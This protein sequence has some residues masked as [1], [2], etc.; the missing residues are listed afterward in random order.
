MG[1][2]IDTYRKDRQ[3]W[4]TGCDIHPD[5]PYRAIADAANNI[6]EALRTAVRIVRTQA[7]GE[8]AEV[9]I[10]YGQEG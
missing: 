9:I 6:Y 7:D 10:Q 3:D 1:Y 2:R 5:T 8:Q 4:Q